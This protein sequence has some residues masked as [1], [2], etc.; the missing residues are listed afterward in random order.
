MG[1]SRSANG[2]ATNSPIE[3]AGSGL[4]YPLG[5]G[6]GQ[7]GAQLGSGRAGAG[8]PSKEYGSRLFPKR[9][10]TLFPLSFANYLH[11]TDNDL[12]HA[13][14]RPRKASHLCSGDHHPP[15]ADTRPL[16]VKSSQSRQAVT[17]SPISMQA[18]HK[19]AL[20]PPAKVLRTRLVEDAQAQYPHDSLQLAPPMVSTVARNHHLALQAHRI[21][22]QAA[23]MARPHRTTSSSKLRPAP[24]IPAARHYF[25]D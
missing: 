19:Q 17:A 16:S 3:P 12:V 6:L 11:L 14:F 1:G 21:L 20:H 5:N 18:L 9:W 23:Y 15:A 10:A 7:A 4:R 2:S 13:R 8:S 22:R 25:Q 24:P